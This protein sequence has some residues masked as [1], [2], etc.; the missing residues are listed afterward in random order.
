M[1]EQAPVTPGALALP[2]SARADDRTNADCIYHAVPLRERVLADNLVGDTRDMHYWADRWPKDPTTRTPTF[3][4]VSELDWQAANARAVAGADNV[5]VRDDAVQDELR[6]TLVE[7][8]A[9]LLEMFASK[10]EDK[11]LSKD[12]EQ[13]R[14]L[15]NVCMYP[16]VYG[17][18]HVLPVGTCIT[19]DTWKSHLGGGSPAVPPAAPFTKARHI[20]EAVVSK[21]FQWLPADFAV[22]GDG[23]VAIRSYINQLHPETHRSLYET[24]ARVFE[25]AL[26]LLEE[27]LGRLRSPVPPCIEPLEPHEYYLQQTGGDDDSEYEDEYE[28][29]EEIEALEPPAEYYPE[30]FAFLPYRLRDR[31]LKVISKVVTIEL[32]PELPVYPAAFWKKESNGWHFEG[33]RRPWVVD[34]AANEAIVATALE[35]RS[36]I[37]L[38]ATDPRFPRFLGDIYGIRNGRELLLKRPGVTPSH[39]R[40]V[41]YP[42]TYQH[43]DAAFKLAD[44]KRK[45]SVTMVVFHLVDPSSSMGES[46]VSTSRVP[47]QQAEWVGEL[48]AGEQRAFPREV[49]REMVDQIVDDVQSVVT[50]DKAQQVRR[51]V[52][53]DHLAIHSELNKLAFGGK[54][55]RS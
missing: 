5:F 50:L 35:L 9:A 14:H 33:Y 54:T 28:E 29:E 10:K 21:R 11:K 3:G 17:R 38:P 4:F 55:L 44:M 36:A 51:D 32:S 46:V 31:T 40:V 15:V 49:P 37:R 22:D 24:L 2:F 16:L 45:G 53:A 27:T 12:Q 1:N 8:V 42:N 30:Q 48:W 6:V 18:T 41:A 23:R 20:P 26:P 43:R 47:P 25:C 34:G 19:L 7:Q 39:G 52:R 13:E